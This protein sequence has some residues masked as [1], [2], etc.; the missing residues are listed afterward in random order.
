M[1]HLTHQSF[2]SVHSSFSIFLEMV[3]PVNYSSL[4][5][6]LVFFFYISVFYHPQKFLTG[7]SKF[8]INKRHVLGKVTLTFWALGQDY[9][10]FKNLNIF[11]VT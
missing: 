3:M 4:L 7:V 9:S 11:S 1:K 2:A 5:N 6:L 10:T 8:Q